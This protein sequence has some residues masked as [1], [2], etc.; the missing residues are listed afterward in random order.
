[1]VSCTT[2]SQRYPD[3][4]THT[5]ALTLILTL[6]DDRPSIEVALVTF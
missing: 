3:P 2:A 1:M 4:R 5:L 6:A